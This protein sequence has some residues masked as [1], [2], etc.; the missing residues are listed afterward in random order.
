M[1]TFITEDNH[2]SKKQKVLIKMLM[3]MNYN[4]KVIKMFVQQIIHET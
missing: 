4:M 2:E 1:Y 3:V